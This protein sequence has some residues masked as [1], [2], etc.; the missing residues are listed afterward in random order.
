MEEHIRTENAKDWEG[1]YNTFVQSE[2]AY[3][4]VVPLATRFQGIVG[5]KGFYQV[6]NAA[7]PD[8]HITDGGIRHARLL[9]PG[10]DD[11]WHP[12]GRI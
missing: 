6:I 4:D 7:F 8:F 2:A 10:G 3:Y 12:S 11:Q 5:V 9:D 1:V